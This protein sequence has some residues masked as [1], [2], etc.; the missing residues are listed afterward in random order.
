VIILILIIGIGAV[1][2]VLFNSTPK[3]PSV[4]YTVPASQ[5]T[6]SDNTAETG[7]DQNLPKNPIDFAAL[8]DKNPEIFGWIKVPDTNINY[9]LLQ[10]TERDDFYLHAAS[11]KTYS[12]AGSI[13]MEYCNTTEMTDR[14]SVLYGH[15]MMDGSMFANLHKFEDES[16]FNNNKHRYFYIYTPTRKL[17]YEVVSG[18]EYDERHIMNSFNFSDNDVFEEYLD[19]IQNPRSLVR[20]V[21]TKLDHE[22]TVHD[23]IVTLST[24]LDS[25]DGRYLLQGVLVKDEFTR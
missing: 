20:N 4:D 5:D 15:N 2:L 8:H 9:P 13:Y 1:I 16:F 12:F 18:Y 6:V 23:K 10:S 25:G 11:D 22:L 17:T 19:Y 14:V 21:R 3:V 7:I 24:C